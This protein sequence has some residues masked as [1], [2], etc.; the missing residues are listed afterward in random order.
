MGSVRPSPANSLFSKTEKLPRS[1]VSLLA[2]VSQR[3]RRGAGSLA[4]QRVTRSAWTLVCRNGTRADSFLW[5]VTGWA[6][7][8]S[9]KSSKEAEV[10]LADS[11][12]TGGGGGGGG[13]RLLTVRRASHPP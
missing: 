12:W 10:A 9:K 13:R 6:T 4:F 1:R 3:A 7:V 8:Y 5:R 11:S 2:L